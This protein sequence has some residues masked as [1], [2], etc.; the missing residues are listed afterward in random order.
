VFWALGLGLVPIT[1]L[2]LG[3]LRSLQTAAVVV[4]LPLILVG[5]LMSVS[6]VKGLRKAEAAALP[7]SPDGKAR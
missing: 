5:T 4:S 2:I 7:P 3:G 6:L 1:L